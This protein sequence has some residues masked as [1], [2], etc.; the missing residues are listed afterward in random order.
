MT[1]GRWGETKGLLKALFIIKPLKKEMAEVLRLDP[2]HGGAH[3]V[4]A[5]IL[6]QVPGF[7]GGDKKRALEEFET[8][9]RLSPRYTANH[10][11]PPRLPILS[12]RTTRS[13]C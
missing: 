5:E 6:W 12:A 10:Q 13:A 8:A 9:L 2:S 1:I 7:A 4:L 3:N 11:P